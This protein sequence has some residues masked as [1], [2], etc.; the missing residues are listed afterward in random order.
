VFENDHIKVD[1]QTYSPPANSK[2]SRS[3]MRDRSVPIRGS[4]G[5]VSRI[6]Q[7]SASWD[8]PDATANRYWPVSQLA[9]LVAD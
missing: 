8:S 1:Q 4:V 7:L 6:K 9:R 2:V 5:W 3:A